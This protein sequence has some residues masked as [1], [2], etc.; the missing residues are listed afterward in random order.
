MTFDE[1]FERLL[2]HEGGYVWDKNDAGGETK[3]G[4]SKRS[5]PHLDIKNLTQEQAKAVYY[6]DFW[7]P[8]SG[9]DLHD[10]VLW[11]LFDTAVNSGPTTAIRLY[12]K[13]LG[14]ADDGHFGRVSKS[15][16]L[17]M[18]ESDQI[19]R[20]IAERIKFMVKCKTWSSHGAGWMR[21]MAANLYFGAEDS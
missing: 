11:Q 6:K 16:A 18:S 2:G 13:A 9:L 12:Q 4:I 1:M 8:V 19:M 21:R 7:F 17:N 10:G 15:A 14:V 5:Y 20:V 3:W